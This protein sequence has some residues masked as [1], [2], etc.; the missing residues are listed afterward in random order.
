MLPADDDRTARP[1]QRR[2]HPRL[3][4]DPSRPTDPAGACQEHVG[5]GSVVDG[6]YL[7]APDS[8]PADPY[9]TENLLGTRLTDHNVNR[10]P[11]SMG[12]STWTSDREALGGRW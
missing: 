3:R 4:C 6:I 8:S 12:G 10:Q 9:I 11:K 2:S 1:P 7:A 5:S